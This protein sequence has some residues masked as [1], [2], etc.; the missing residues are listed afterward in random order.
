VAKK[1]FYIGSVIALAAALVFL[2]GAIDSRQIF[3]GNILSYFNLEQP[4]LQKELEELKAQNITLKREIILGSIPAASGDFHKALVYSTYPF[5]TRNA[6]VIEGGENR[7]IKRFS[8]VTFEEQVFFGYIDSV[9]EKTSLVK[10]LFD[11]SLEIPVRVGERRI[12]ALLKGGATPLL[13]LIDKDSEIQSGDVILTSD[14]RFPYGLVVGMV[15]EVRD[16]ETET[17]IES[18]IQ[19][20]YIVAKL[21]T[22]HVVK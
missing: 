9:N 17:F 11:G 1:Y 10:T 13:T 5:N 19:L 22:V 15:G 16:S 4:D 8:A 2:N 20:P 14:Q 21:H 7:G 3:F 12:D 6:V 18:T